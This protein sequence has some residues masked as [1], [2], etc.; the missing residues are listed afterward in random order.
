M[1]PPNTPHIPRKTTE[2]DFREAHQAYLRQAPTLILSIANMLDGIILPFRVV[3]LVFA[4]IVLGTG[5]YGTSPSPS[6]QSLRRRL[7]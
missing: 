1:R 2:Q 4:L 3:Q 7:P 5:A 6:P